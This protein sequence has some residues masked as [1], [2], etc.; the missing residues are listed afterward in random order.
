MFR[1]F[2]YGKRSVKNNTPLVN[3]SIYRATLSVNVSDNYMSGM[4]Y[5]FHMKIKE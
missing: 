2:R 4:R 5:Y 3:V 1:L